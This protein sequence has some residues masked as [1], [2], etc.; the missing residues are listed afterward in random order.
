MTEARAAGDARKERAALVSLAVK[1]A[2]TVA[3][4]V[5]AALSGSLALLSEAGNN[6]GDIA[7]TLIS[8]FSIRAAARPA[9]E[10]HH[11]GHAK[12]E[13]VSALVQTGFLFALTLFVLIEAAKRI[14]NGA[15]AVAPGP[16]SFAVLAVSIAVDL[17]RWLSLR[18]LAR[19]TRSA[20][21][22][23]DALNFATD[24]VASLMALIGL[25]AAR[26]GFRYGD[27]VAAVGV[28]AFVGIAGYRLG[29]D[30]IDALVDAAPKGIDA[31]IRRAILAV[32][33]VISVEALRLRPLGSAVAGE[34]VVGVPRALSIERVAA[35]MAAVREAVALSHPGTAVTVTAEPMALDDETVVERVLF[36]ANRRRVPVHH[37]TVQTLG[38]RRAVSFDAEFDGSLSLR[39]AHEVVSAL[40]AAI[41]DELGDGVEIESH[42]EPLEAAELDGRDCDGERRAAVLAALRSRMP[43]D[44]VLRLVHDVRVRETAAGLIVNYH[45]LADP[46]LDVETVHR[47]VD[48]L[49]R[50]VREHCS[51]I[52]RI[53]GHAEPA[54]P[55][56]PSWEGHRPL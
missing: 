12:V 25:A 39:E 19:E 31:P 6:L 13:A 44:G 2:L 42:I 8:F 16:F 15:G 48:L 20:A 4:F 22:A 45:C 10:D 24:I 5:A 17:A 47:H 26:L 51:G 41:A 34:A 28:A 23:A 56:D 40:E 32:P 27:A 49:D 9:D 38:T 18:R 50:D 11:F 35:I 1:L 53:V 55:A 3:K 30:T 54:S 21:L 29:R 36:I 52:V 37:V 33:G 7:T 43:V 14:V 46:A